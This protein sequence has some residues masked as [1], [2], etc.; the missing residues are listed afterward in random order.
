MVWEQY[1]EPGAGYTLM[2]PDSHYEWQGIPVDINSHGLRGP[3]TTYEKPPAT[4]R[5]L[6]LGDSVVMGWGVR[7]EDTYGQQLE[8]L[9]NE[10]GSGDLRYEVINA[11]VPGWNLDNALAYLQ[12]EGL[13]YEPD[14]ILLDLTIANDINGKSALLADNQP[15]LLKWLGDQHLFL[16]LPTEPSGMGESA[17]PGQGPC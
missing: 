12:A 15:A 6:N 2:K 17:C 3:E 14:L 7:E 1:P 9:L 8:Q 4:F 11:G 10:E 16:A 5:I 13:K